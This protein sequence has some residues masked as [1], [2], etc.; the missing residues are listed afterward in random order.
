MYP[1]DFGYILLTM[2]ATIIMMEFRFFKIEIQRFLNPFQVYTL[3]H[4]SDA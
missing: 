3:I 2:A 4:R 1:P